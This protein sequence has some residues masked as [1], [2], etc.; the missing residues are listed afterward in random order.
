MFAPM[1]V[2]VDTKFGEAFLP[3]LPARLDRSLNIRGPKRI[4]LARI[5]RRCWHHGSRA[6]HVVAAS[7]VFGAIVTVNVLTIVT[8]RSRLGTC[9][10]GNVSSQRMCLLL[11]ILQPFRDLVWLRLEGPPRD[12]VIVRIGDSELFSE[13]ERRITQRPDFRLR[14]SSSV[15]PPSSSY[16]VC[17][18]NTE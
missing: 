5:S 10:C 17:F 12:P 18:C 3:R 16:L 9:H 14:T 15:P 1:R 4:G 8:L 13:R 2:R 7:F 6:V 11:Q